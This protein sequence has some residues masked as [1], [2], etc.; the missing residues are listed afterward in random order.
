MPDLDLGYPGLVLAALA[1][2][3]A[4]AVVAGAST[5][6]TAFGAY[7]P[8]WD[9]ASDL[10]AQAE[11]VGAETTIVRETD[12]YDELNASGTVAVVLSPDRAYA[13]NDSERVRRFVERGGTLVVAEDYGEHAN[14][15]LAAV[16]AEA[17]IDGRPLRDER[18]NYRSPAMP[19][20]TNV[21][22][23]SNATNVTLAGVDSLALNHGTVVRPNG[24]ANGSGADVLVASSEYAY[25]DANRNEE[26]DE[27]ERL[28]SRPVVT[29]ERVGDG[30]VIVVSDP[31]ALI[32]AMLD[33]PDNRAFVRA[34][35]AGA[36]R[37]ALDYSHAAQLPPL[38][39]AVVVLREAVALQVVLGGLL[40]AGAALWVRWPALRGRGALADLRRALGIADESPREPGLD[41]AAAAAF[42]RRRHPDW[43][44][45]R[46]ERV[47]RS[48]LREGTDEGDRDPGGKRDG[49][50]K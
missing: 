32:N 4:L 10:R 26:L 38:A 2:V 20:A 41:A 12:R 3:V 23:G 8:Q 37:V 18:R 49:E 15:L 11:A 5:S 28:S 50:R 21:T 17:R 47:V 44:E 24:T 43:D 1:L 29:A 46:V 14:P 31:S 35:F 33:R 9:G 16:G 30:L 7:N 42:L 19:V 6:G 22:N 36:D 45:E 40:V 13:A 39:L 34:L 27:G 25:L 48:Q